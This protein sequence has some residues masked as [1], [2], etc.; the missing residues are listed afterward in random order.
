MTAQTPTMSKTPILPSI[1]REKNKTTFEQSN[2][3]KG[4]DDFS[5][6]GKLTNA[7]AQRI[8]AVL[9]EIQRKVAI[10]GFFPDAT[11]RKVASILTGEGFNLLKVLLSPCLT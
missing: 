6:S 9:Q 2:N 1:K 3:S 11:E 4:I 8:M 7:E 5:Y 10:I